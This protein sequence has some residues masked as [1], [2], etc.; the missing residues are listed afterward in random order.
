MMRFIGLRDGGFARAALMACTL[1]LFATQSLAFIHAQN[2]G[3]EP[4]SHDG[5]QCAFAKGVPEDDF[6]APAAIAPVL[7][8]AFIASKASQPVT[9]V[10]KRALPVLH[11]PRAPPSF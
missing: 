3:E 2:Y 11:G 6:V 7:N 10:S 8:P 9:G 1:F 5:V 4:H